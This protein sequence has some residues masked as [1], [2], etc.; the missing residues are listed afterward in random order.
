MF[1]PS[2][3][4]CNGRVP[5]GE[6]RL[7]RRDPTL[8]NNALVILPFEEL[9]ATAIGPTGMSDGHCVLGRGEVSI[10]IKD[11]VA[12]GIV[13]FQLAITVKDRGCPVHIDVDIATVSVLGP[14]DAETGT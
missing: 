4:V 10:A 11:G 2:P 8:R 5:V 9:G 14:N 13:A 1:S 7:D 12:D 3:H 6:V